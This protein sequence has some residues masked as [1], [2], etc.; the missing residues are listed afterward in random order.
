[1]RPITGRGSV[2]ERSNLGTVT[3]AAIL[4]ACNEAPRLSAVLDALVLVGR[5][6]EIVVVDDGSTD[7]TAEIA[8][9]H[10]LCRAGRLIVLRHNNNRG[11]GVAL[12]TGAERVA[13]SFLLFLD[14][15]LIGLTPAHIT[16]LLEPICRGD[17]MA[18]A[19]FRDSR[20]APTLSHTLFPDISGQ[21]AL[22]RV[23]FDSL[24]PDSAHGFGIELA[25]TR[26][27]RKE[28]YSKVVVEWKGVSHAMKEEKFGLARGL[29]LRLRM[30]AEMVAG[31][32][33]AG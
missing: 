22:R 27:C 9:A 28:G 33:R 3:F 20:F 19:T 17:D 16:A 31:W 29:T 18:V 13:A 32:V 1:M 24:P 23:V 2:P 21:R 12:R 14:A 11:K 4:P 10:P 26:H 5:I 25:L 30:Y 7:G 15:D 8:E 6:S